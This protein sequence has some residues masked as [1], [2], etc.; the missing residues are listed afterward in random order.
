MSH[1]VFVCCG[2]PVEVDP[3][4]GPTVQLA[5]LCLHDAPCMGLANA[6]NLTDI[7]AQATGAVETE[8]VVPGTTEV[9]GTDG[10]NEGG[11]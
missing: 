6:V 5:H 3:I 7:Q 9:V 8:A 1:Y 2:R 10:S 4:N 11:Q